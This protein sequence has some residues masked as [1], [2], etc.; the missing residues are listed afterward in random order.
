VLTVPAFRR[1]GLGAAVA[2]IATDDALDSGLIAQCRS[3]RDNLA[4]RALAA[5]TG[6]RELGTYSAVTLSRSTL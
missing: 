5:R 2:G 4:S 1:R 6:F 3:P